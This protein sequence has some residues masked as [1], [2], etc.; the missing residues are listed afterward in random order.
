MPLCGFN[1]KMITGI[2]IFSEGLFEATIER[3]LENKVDDLTAV[4]REVREIDLFIKSLH[5]QYRTPEDTA[6]K[7]AEMIYGIAVFSGSLFESTLAHN[8]HSTVDLKETF[9]N[10]V[11]KLSEFLERL[12]NKHQELKKINTP[13]ETMKK[14]VQWIDEND[15]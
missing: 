8:G 6:K 13:E 3:G 9:E 1:K 10:Q 12:E 5:N 14:A 11:K 4:K 2:V 15:K 7:M